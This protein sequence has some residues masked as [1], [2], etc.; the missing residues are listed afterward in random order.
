MNPT[1]R[2]SFSV[3]DRGHVAL[4]VFDVQGRLV[5]TLIDEVHE[6]GRYSA[7][8]DGRNNRGRRVASGVYFYRITT[9]VWSQSRK[10]VIL[11]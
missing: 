4:R 5:R 1:A 7:A 3:R 2:I 9:P 11:K 10:M 6:P 8:W